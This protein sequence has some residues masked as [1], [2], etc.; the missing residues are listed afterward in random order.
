MTPATRDLL[1]T[2]LRS[3]YT[4]LAAWEAWLAQQPPSARTTLNAA[5]IR[6]AKGSLTGWE[7]W[8]SRQ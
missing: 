8:F 2:L 1:E 4:A 6:A 5:L 7:R 3:A